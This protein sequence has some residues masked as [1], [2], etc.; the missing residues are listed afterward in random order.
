VQQLEH[1]LGRRDLKV[2]VGLESPLKIQAFLDR[3]PY[4]A[5]PIYRCPRRVLQDRK[6]HCYDGALFAAAMLRRLGYPPL[7]L[8]MF[9]VRDDDHIL[10]LYKKDGLW[11][12]VAKSN[13]VG[14]RY[15]EP[16]YRTLRELVMS[17]FELFFNV[18]RQKT[19]R[20][21]T[22]PLNMSTFDRLD[23]MVRDE[24]METVAHRLDKIRRIPLLSERS[25][26]G[27]CLTDE[28]S[29][30]AGMEGVNRAGL[31]KPGL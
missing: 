4:S 18:D 14:L 21:Y 24:A 28:R 11:G 30:R 3:I 5:D 23:W 1:V 12:A 29:Y 31:Y 13:F 6:A 17:Y 15:R 20:S 16:I 10:A 27:L 22:L 8:D 26:Q 25:I 7:I 2:L 19:L 9:A